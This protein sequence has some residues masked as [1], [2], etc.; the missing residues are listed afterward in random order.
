[1]HH[2]VVLIT[3]HGGDNFLGLAG[4]AVVE[5]LRDGTHE[6]RFA[7]VFVC[8]I[9]VATHDVVA[10][11]FL[12]AAVCRDEFEFA[13]LNGYV[14]RNFVEELLDPIR[15]V[16]NSPRNENFPAEVPRTRVEKGVS[17][18]SFGA[19]PPKGSGEPRISR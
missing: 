4:L 6:T 2:D 11:G 15:V 9:A 8:L 1:M 3:G 18:F 19:S 13:I 7:A 14:T 10:K 5:C 17:R 16:G 12:E